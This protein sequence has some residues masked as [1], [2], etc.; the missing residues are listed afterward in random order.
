MHKNKRKIINSI[1]L[2]LSTLAALAGIAILFWIIG[3]LLFKGLSVISLDTFTQDGTPPGMEGGGLRQA[4]IG[5]LMLTGIAMGIGIPV[6]MLAGTYL[7]EYGQ[8]S[9]VANFIRDLS[10]IMMSAPSI[11]V[12]VFVYGIM[13][14]PVHHFSGWA[15]SVAL[16]ILAVPVIIR[17]TDDMLSLVPQTLREAAYALGAPKW[18]VIFQVVYKGAAVGLMTGILLGVARVAGETAPLLFTSFNNNFF[19]LNMNDSIASLTVTMF[20]YAASPYEDWQKLGWAAAAILTFA[21][22]FVNIMSRIIM[23]I[24]KGKR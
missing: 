4:L 5:H 7:S 2:A 20:G 16:A 23:K 12:G 6:G 22:L 8:G 21:V 1:V 9:R 13:V 11:V 14:A 24:K 10:D 18:K 15:G 3:V 19:S 17:T